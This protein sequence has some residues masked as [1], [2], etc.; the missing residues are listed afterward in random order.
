MWVSV[1]M[2]VV[3]KLDAGLSTEKQRLCT[4]GDS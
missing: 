1:E 3:C 4:K 2:G